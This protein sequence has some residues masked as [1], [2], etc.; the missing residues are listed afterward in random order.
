MSNTWDIWRGEKVRL[1]GWEPGDWQHDQRSL[2]DS[3]ASRTGDI[4]DADSLERHS[5]WLK[6]NG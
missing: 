4:T 6:R 5:E 2:A 1:R 3:E